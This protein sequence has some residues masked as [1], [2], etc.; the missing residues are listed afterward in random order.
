MANEFD[1]NVYCDFNAT[2]AAAIAG[3]DILLTIFNS[4]GEKLLAVAGQQGL[5]IN[6]SADSIEVDVYKRQPEILQKHIDKHKALQPRYERLGKMYKGD[7]EILH[8]TQKEAYKPD[9]RLVVNFAKYIVD[10]LNGYFIG[11]PVKVTH[12]HEPTAEYL[13]FL[14]KY[15]D[16]DDNNAE[17]SKLCLLYT[18][19]CV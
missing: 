12:D 14:N 8:Q 16:Q 2:A 9:N 18:S 5:T 7:H 19:R 1:N 11:I 17:L 10:T 6:R 15:N 13:D 4:T 3:A